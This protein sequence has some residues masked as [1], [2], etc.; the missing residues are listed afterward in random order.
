[1]KLENNDLQHLKGFSKTSLHYCTHPFFNRFGCDLVGLP[2][3]NCTALST[4]RDRQLSR[5]KTRGTDPAIHLK[6]KP[7]ESPQEHPD[8]FLHQ[9]PTP[10]NES[11]SNI[12]HHSPQP[13]PFHPHCASSRCALTYPVYIQMAEF[14]NKYIHRNHSTNQTSTNQLFNHSTTQLIKHSA[15]QLFN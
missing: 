9:Q 8:T 13:P 2:R 14:I 15:N 7:S 6:S 1:M 11:P 12:F 3:L 10:T 4:G 5:G